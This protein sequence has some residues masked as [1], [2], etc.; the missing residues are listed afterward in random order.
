LGHAIGREAVLLH[1]VLERRRR[2]EGVHADRRAV[3]P[4][5]AIPAQRR[6]L[7]DRNTSGDLGRQDAVAV[8]LIWRVA[9]GEG[10]ARAPPRADA[11]G[12]QRL[13]GLERQRHLAAGGDQDYL[14][15]AATRV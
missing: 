1:H 14:R 10:G 7:L 5:I 3:R 8:L 2:A 9:Q 12:G 4:D 11:G 15:V 13:V 6:R